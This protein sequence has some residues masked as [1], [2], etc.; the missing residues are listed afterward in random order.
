MLIVR[1]FFIPALGAFYLSSVENKE[2]IL[3]N[4]ADKNK[5]INLILFMVTNDNPASCKRSN[6]VSIKPV[7]TIRRLTITVIF[8]LFI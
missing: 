7:K 1:A 5:P 2:V 3:G 4:A 6:L 8:D